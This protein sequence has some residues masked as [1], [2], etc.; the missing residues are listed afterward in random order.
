MNFDEKTC[1]K[2][3]IPTASNEGRCTII[4]VKYLLFVHNTFILKCNQEM[5]KREK[6]MILSLNT[7]V[8]KEK[9]SRIESTQDIEAERF[10]KHR[11][12]FSDMIYSNH[13]HT[14]L[15]VI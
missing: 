13:C 4:L 15:T 5:T 3:L 2:Y 1:M 9:A 12:P 14:I 7:G 10:V 6:E 8:Q 11:N